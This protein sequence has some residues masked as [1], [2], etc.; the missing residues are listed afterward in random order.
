MAAS[1][2]AVA[3]LLRRAVRL[4]HRA[5]HEIAP[6]S[7]RLPLELVLSILELAA[8]RFVFE[9]ALWTSQLLYI[10][11]AVRNL[12]EP[13]LL[14]IVMAAERQSHAPG[15]L[16]LSRLC[17]LASDPRRSSMVKC[18]VFP[19]AS[20]FTLQPSHIPITF[21]GPIVIPQSVRSTLPTS[22]TGLVQVTW[23]P[24][25][26]DYVVLNVTISAAPSSFQALAADHASPHND[27]NA[28]TTVSTKR[29]FVYIRSTLR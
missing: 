15:A 16:S 8:R 14:E 2:H 17:N 24:P 29:S 28:D 22:K 5:P 27:V 20:N 21:N 6:A 4:M 7:Q 23:W 9:D 25:T 26:T 18:I 11:R 19:S 13:L 1:A 10:N 3:E 12:V